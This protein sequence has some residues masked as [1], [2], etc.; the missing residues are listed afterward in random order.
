MNIELNQKQIDEIVMLVLASKLGS[1]EELAKMTGYNQIELKRIIAVYPEIKEA[2]EVKRQSQTE[3]LL[4]LGLVTLT[5]KKAINSKAEVDLM[6]TV[7]DGIGSSYGY[8]KQDTNININNSN[9]TILQLSD[10][11]LEIELQELDNLDND[12]N[13]AVNN[14]TPKSY[15]SVPNPD[16]ENDTKDSNKSKSKK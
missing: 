1:L 9:D 13:I 3:S 6:K 16:K 7:L 15:L 12:N 10:E 14:D 8:G 5:S 2:V 4:Q 11:E